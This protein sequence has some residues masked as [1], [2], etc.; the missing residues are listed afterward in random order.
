[1]R[2]PAASEP[3]RPGRGRPPVDAVGSSAVY[4]AQPD[5]L[6]ITPKFSD[7]PY[8]ERLGKEREKLS[9]PNKTLLGHDIVKTQVLL[10]V[11]DGNVVYEY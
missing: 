9:W 7:N 3:D 8:R 4:T 11:M 5:R 2:A 10:T 6:A 1:M